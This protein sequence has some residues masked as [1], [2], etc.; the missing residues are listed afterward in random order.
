MGWKPMM[1]RCRVCDQA[2]L[3]AAT[4]FPAPTPVIHR[5]LG[6][7]VAKEACRW[8]AW[9][10]RALVEGAGRGRRGRL[11][12]GRGAGIGGAHFR[13]AAGGCGFKGEVG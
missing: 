4:G 6:F 3:S 12:A 10:R 9:F 13:V 1:L 2:E 11:C 7:G 8:F 5:Q